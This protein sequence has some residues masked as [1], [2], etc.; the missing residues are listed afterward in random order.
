[1]GS[2]ISQRLMMPFDLF[3]FF[4]CNSCAKCHVC[5]CLFIVV[6]VMLDGRDIRELN[7][8]WLRN[9][10]GIVSQEPVL[11]GTTIRENIAF[12]SLSE[13]VTL[14]E[15]QEAA[16]LANAHNFVSALPDVSPSNIFLQCMATLLFMCSVRC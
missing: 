10:I 6:Q 8:R 4:L 13:N 5:S 7:V 2:V 11:F 16:K 3:R 1:M 14:E 9:Q 15:V 12:G